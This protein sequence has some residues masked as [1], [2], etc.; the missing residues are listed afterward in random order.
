MDRA[1]ETNELSDS[2][3]DQEGVGS[4][5][6]IIRLA[7]AFQAS[8]ALFV[9]TEFGIADLLASG[10]MTIR[11]IAQ[12]TRTD[13]G[14]MQRMMRALAAFGFF[15]DLGDDTFELTPTGQYLRADW[16]Q[17][18]R[19]LVL[20]YGSDHSRQMF[21]SL[22]DCLRTGKNAFEIQFG[23]ASSYDHLDNHVDLARTFNNGMSAISAITGP[24]A[25][26]AYDFARVRHI[27]DVGG[28]HGKVLASILQEN[29]R[30]RGTL[31]DLPRVVDGALPLLSE[32]GVADRCDIAGGDMFVSVP[33]GGDLYLLSH[34]MHNWDDSRATL[35]LQACRRAMTEQGK[36][37]I[38]DRV[39]PE[40]IAPDPTIQS[41]VLIDLTMMIRTG[42]GKERTASEFLSLLSA[43]NLRLTRVIPTE[44]SE[45][46]IEAMPW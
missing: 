43:S 28:G 34:V 38:L 20:M 5:A 36:L 29:L 14:M 7:L 26:R 33:A 23:S 40:K 42:G 8:H 2:V 16:P 13:L 24:A 10:G 17:S 12:R 6:A 27:V 46:L 18:V 19:S 41:N 9:A 30:L 35:V 37:L 45:S 1:C 32:E 11:E 4:P 31:F 39:L 3:L 25:A 44:T 15:K 22:G 21:S